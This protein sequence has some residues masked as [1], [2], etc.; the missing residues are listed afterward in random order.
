MSLPGCHSA[1][2][3]NYTIGQ[4]ET[5]HR[6]DSAGLEPQLCHIIVFD[7]EHNLVHLSVHLII[8]SAVQPISRAPIHPSMPSTGD[9][10]LLKFSFSFII[11]KGVN[12]YFLVLFSWFLKIHEM[13]QTQYLIFSRVSVNSS[14]FFLLPPPPNSCIKHTCTH[15]HTLRLIT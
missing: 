10:K 1:E 13:C 14:T 12:N 11:C 3:S 4:W 2:S 6:W 5:A 15:T 9:F 7:L 8:P